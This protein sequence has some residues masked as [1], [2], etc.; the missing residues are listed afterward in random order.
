[1]NISEIYR[2]KYTIIF[3]LFLV[4]LVSI[5]VSR[6]YSGSRMGIRIT[7]TDDY[8]K[9][10]IEGMSS[11]NIF[12][13]S[14]PS[15][16]TLSV[17]G[18][19]KLGNMLTWEMNI[20]FIVSGGSGSWRPLI[21]DMYNSINTGR[22]WGVWISNQNSIHWSWKDRTWEPR[23][24]VLS[25]KSYI[26]TV[27]STPTTLTLILNNRSDGTS[28]KDTFNTTDKKM[29]TMTTNGP[30]SIGGWS[31]NNERFQGSI[32]SITVTQ[33][34]ATTLKC[35]RKDKSYCVFKDYSTNDFNGICNAP[36]RGQ[37]NYKGLYEYTDAQF[38]G[39][40][41]ELYDRNSGGDPNRSERANVID[42]VN[43][44]KNVSGYEYL[45]NTKA[46]KAQQAVM[47][48]AIAAEAKATADAAAV[49][50][51]ADA[52]AKTRTAVEARA[53]AKREENARIEAKARASATALSKSK[54]LA[55]ARV[56]KEQTQKADEQAKT[57][58]SEAA[59]A[60]ARV[61]ERASAEKKARM[62]FKTKADATASLEKEAAIAK[63]AA[64]KEA[65]LKKAKILDAEAKAAESKAS[66]EAK[67]LAEAKAVETNRNAAKDKANAEAKAAAEAKDMAE[68][69]ATK[70]IEESA[71]AS[72]VA[73]AI[74]KTHAKA[75]SNALAKEKIKKEADINF[76]NK[77]NAANKAKL[78][79]RTNS[80]NVSDGKN[81]SSAYNRENVFSEE[82]Y[83]EST[84][85]AA[86]ITNTAS[87]ASR[88]DRT[89]KSYCIF[90]DYTTSGNGKC[91]GPTSEQGIYSDINTYDDNKF[92]DWLDSLYNRNAGSNPLQ[93]ERANVID[94]VNRCKS[95][96]GYEYLS[97]TL[98]G[99]ASPIQAT[100]SDAFMFPTAKSAVSQSN[101]PI[102]GTNSA[103]IG[104]NPS[105]DIKGP[106]NFFYT[107]NNYV[108][109]DEAATLAKNAFISSIP[110]N[111]PGITPYQPPVSI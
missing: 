49:K 55:E 68:A 10:V 87:I 44:C 92:I 27:S 9:G 76:N 62:E 37:E 65:A 69:K 59:K 94:Y 7:P 67:A 51:K 14:N 45:K 63:S 66:I 4:I 104:M 54:A 11:T 78:R 100:T 50:A 2:S 43:R 106:K 103:T 29:Y 86:P 1:M 22:G 108:L 28:Q 36:T 88:C 70:E 73:D 23:F 98:A 90:R 31:K 77:I 80:L 74:S 81:T 48:A 17:N 52:E 96:A 107:T 93:S 40:L 83:P 18:F 39:W 38:T 33:S 110:R 30:V 5:W 47:D 105:S 97:K 21:G 25:N 24:Q 41:D 6:V 13:I 109:K 58:A 32:Y 79:A 53:T 72:A 60:R 12:S 8:S 91:K 111:S 82:V 102:Q 101:A 56:A 34:E 26:L 85:R 19:P 75:E 15:I 57:A 3:I 46:H 95:I 61:A 84:I 71:K 42:Y 64:E 99:I 35:D 16:P 20:S 89:D